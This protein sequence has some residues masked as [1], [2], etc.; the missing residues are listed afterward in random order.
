MNKNF[1]EISNLCKN[2][3]QIEAYKTLF[4]NQCK[5]LLYGGAAH[6]GK[7]Y[8][9]RWIALGLG[10]YYS[11]KYNIKNVPIGLFSEDYP[12]LKDRQIAKIKREFPP[13][14]GKLKE[15]RDEGY[16]FEAEEKYG[17]FRILLRNLDDP[18][19][20][21]SAEFAA[22]LVEE[23]TKNP[24]GTF[25]D[26]RFRLRYT[27]T[28]PIY[29][30]GEKVG[31]DQVMIT[32]PKFIGVTNPGG[33]GHAWVRKFWIEPDPNNLDVEQDRF[34][35]V[36]SLPEDNPY[37]TDEYLKQLDSM[38]EAK[39]KAW[40]D[41]SWDVFEGQVFSEWNRNIHVVKPFQIPK[42]WKRY[43][44]MD[45]GSNK[46]FAIGWYA[47]N[48]DGQSFLYRELYMNKID[49][50]AKYNLPLTARR[51]A[52]VIL[53]INKKSDEDYEYM[54]ADPS[55]WNKILLGEDSKIQEGESY[56]EIMMD[57]GLKMIRAD[58]NRQN[59][60]NRYQE[61]LSIKK[62]VP[63]YRVFSTCYDTIRTIPALIYD[64]TRIE[65]VDTGAE[66]HCY[67][68]DRYYFMSRPVASERQDESLT[69]VQKH[70]NELRK[71]QGEND[72]E[73]QEVI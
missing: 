20:Y 70:L 5:Y 33:I 42:E 65:D 16:M 24:V 68:R 54:I 28:R 12:T 67:D 43:I 71:N 49:F 13:W 3:R 48:Y 41:G 64:K 57:E 10:L 32:D 37:T 39:R 73:N 46:P 1:T 55:M 44:A 22:I 9:L 34:V 63:E 4:N 40:R 23:L 72:Y 7:S 29:K 53:D 25:E 62:G 45:W 2:D 36:R 61:A 59:G 27:G 38:P 8:F 31:E 17:A 19:K 26:L 58:N 60:L 15:D 66:D 52:R 35:F 51:L 69:V 47:Q 50:E 6:G 21:A 30:D 18:S 56:A 11:S 14:L